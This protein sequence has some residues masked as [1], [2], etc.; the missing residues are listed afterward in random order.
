MGI[1]SPIFINFSLDIFE[2]KSSVVAVLCYSF[3]GN[4][5][6]YFKTITP[7]NHRKTQNRNKLKDKE[8]W[9]VVCCYG[10]AE[11]V[12]KFSKGIVIDLASFFFFSEKQNL[13][14]WNDRVGYWLQYYQLPPSSPRN[15][16]VK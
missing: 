14:L 5:I 2:T 15:D 1:Y 10:D 16:N 7:L 9:D 3:T 4:E 6:I 13:R 8:S 12:V 11:M